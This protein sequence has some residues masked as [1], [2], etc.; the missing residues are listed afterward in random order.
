MDEWG[1]IGPIRPRHLIEAHRRMKVQNKT[2]QS[3]QAYK[4]P[5]LHR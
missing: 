1:E 5:L 2:P 3:K 4:K